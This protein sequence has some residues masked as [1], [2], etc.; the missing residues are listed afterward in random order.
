MSSDYLYTTP[1]DDAILITLVADQTNDQGVPTL[2]GEYARLR[3]YVEAYD[4]VDVELDMGLAYTLIFPDVLTVT[5]ANITANTAGGWGT[6]A[7]TPTITAADNRI[8]H[9]VGRAAIL[10][11][12][13]PGLFVTI[14]FEMDAA[15]NTGDRIGTFW[16]DED[17]DM[18]YGF[19]F[20]L[21]LFGFDMDYLYFNFEN[22]SFEVS[23][24]PI[25]SAVTIS[26]DSD[27]VIGAGADMLIVNINRTGTEALP[28]N[29]VYVV[30]MV[31]GGDAGVARW[32]STTPVTIP[33]LAASPL[34]VETGLY[35]DA[36]Q[37]ISVWLM[38]APTFDT[39]LLW[40]DNIASY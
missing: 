3:M 36:G 8:D 16:C 38:P 24:D 20:E 1:P 11:A 13:Q 21:D 2:G 10:D 7:P 4:F 35:P 31:S 26:L 5:S 18:V 19:E 27:D 9:T 28:T 34:A 32:I 39:G 30:V 17:D 37:D 23:D 14:L 22:A 12:T 33:T 15:V 25:P 29:N 6:V 40:S